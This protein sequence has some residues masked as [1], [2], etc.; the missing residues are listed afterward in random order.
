MQGWKSA[1]RCDRRK[2]AGGIH[3]VRCRW[4][5][6]QG[7]GAGT[8]KRRRRGEETRDT[9]YC[10]G[11]ATLEDIAA[12]SSVAHEAEHAVTPFGASAAGTNFA[13]ETYWADMTWLASEA[14]ASFVQG[15]F[16]ECVKVEDLEAVGAIPL[17]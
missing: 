1:P 5:Q 2:A 16:A 6:R 9:Y 14:W 8:Q 17:E 12:S 13:P 10:I 11:L 4:G 3:K 15:C 7:H